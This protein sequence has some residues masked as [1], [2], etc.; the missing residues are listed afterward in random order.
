MI[1]TIFL[2]I[3]PNKTIYSIPREKINPNERWI[4]HVHCEGARFHVLNYSG[5]IGIDGKVKAEIHCSE[6]DCIYN[7]PES[8]QS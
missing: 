6:P 5:K 3:D 2:E 7:K 4:K 8:E 1:P